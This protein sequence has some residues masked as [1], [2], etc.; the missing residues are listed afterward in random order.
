MENK[1]ED[2]VRKRWEQEAQEKT[3]RTETMQQRPK[4]RVRAIEYTARLNG[5]T[6]EDN[7]NEQGGASRSSNRRVGGGARGGRKTNT[8]TRSTTVESNEGVVI[9][10]D[11]ELD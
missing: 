11:E 8:K 3:D 1:A 6:L 9:D 4:K 7:T 10:L 5:G 2:E